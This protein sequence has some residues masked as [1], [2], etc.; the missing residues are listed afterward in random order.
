MAKGYKG[1]AFVN[2]QMPFNK[3]IEHEAARLLVESDPDITDSQFEKDLPAVKKALKLA[4]AE[5]C[6]KI[7]VISPFEPDEIK[8]SEMDPESF[9]LLTESNIRRICEE[10]METG[11]GVAQAGRIV[12]FPAETTMEYF[13]T[14]NA[15]YAA[16]MPTR[17][18]VFA[19]HVNM[20]IGA[21]QSHLAKRILEKPMNWQNLS[22][23]LER[24]HAEDFSDKKVSKKEVKA[25]SQLEALQR[26]LS[27]AVTPGEQRR[28]GTPPRQLKAPQE[29]PE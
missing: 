11:L 26:Q 1:R 4:A 5:K 17:K 6:A 8:L 14:G 20:A 3:A 9:D 27:G 24:C 7:E 2:R 18:A 13:A 15:D 16:G 12:G 28:N 25:N 22:F 29:P 23:M 10:I 21:L 19:Y